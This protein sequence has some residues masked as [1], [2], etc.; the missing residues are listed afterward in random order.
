MLTI[1]GPQAAGNEPEAER[2]P[3]HPENW[4][5]SRYCYK[6]VVRQNE[7][8]T[9]WTAGQAK[10]IEG[11][12]KTRLHKIWEQ[13]LKGTYLL[14]AT[15]ADMSQPFTHQCGFFSSQE[16]HCDTLCRVIFTESVSWAWS[17]LMRSRCMRMTKRR[18]YFSNSFIFSSISVTTALEIAL[19]FSMIVRACG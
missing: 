6:I 12:L 14:S 17:R 10:E 11:C 18:K 7:C 2:I 8:T 1:D 9:E 16:K 13:L 5:F 3:K 15:H 4:G 19:A